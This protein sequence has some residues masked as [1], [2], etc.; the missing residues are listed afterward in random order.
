MLYLLIGSISFTF[1]IVYDINNITLQNRLLKSFF[2]VGCI[3]LIYSTMM[4]S[5]FE[6]PSFSLP[7]FMKVFVSLGGLISFALL[8]YTLFF[9]LPWK[10]TYVSLKSN[11]V[12]VNQGI[13]A[14]CRHPGVIWFI[15]FYFFYWLFTGITLMMW[16]GITFS[17]LN[18]IYILLQEKYI[19]CKLFIDYDL[20]QKSTPFF[21]PNCS[22]I[23]RCFNA[24]KMREEI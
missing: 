3:M 9:A 16:A 13:Y 5:I 12:V 2:V 17:I 6:Q 15:L 14:L 8:I 10:I 4:I 11:D 20:Y 18:L 19:F 22:S 1:F 24:M 21:I 7:I 23:N